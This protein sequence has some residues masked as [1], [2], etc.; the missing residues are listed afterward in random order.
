MIHSWIHN[1]TWLTSLKSDGLSLI[2]HCLLDPDD[3]VSAPPLG[4]N[5]ERKINYYLAHIPIKVYIQD[6]QGTF[7]MTIKASWTMQELMAKYTNRRFV[8]AGAG[9]QNSL[10]SNLSTALGPLQN[11]MVINL[12][13]RIP[14]APP[15]AE[16]LPGAF[17]ISVRGLS[18]GTNHVFVLPDDTF[19]TLR[20]R[21]MNVPAIKLYILENIVNFLP[22]DLLIT[23]GAEDTTT[24][25]TAGTVSENNLG[26]HGPTLYLTRRIRGGARKG[27]AKVK[28]N[29]KLHTTR[30]K[31]HYSGCIMSKAE[32]V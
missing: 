23:S 28:K 9:R 26:P 31:C 21:L 11:G 4:A 27:M 17:Q 15:C 30:A 13:M 8:V 22:A 12:N 5:K 3:A 20:I 32:L 10:N 1:T 19:E 7:P 16:G 18:E 24:P 29:E 25:L 6:P 2:N 14:S